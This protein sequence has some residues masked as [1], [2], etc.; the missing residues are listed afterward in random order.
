[1]KKIISTIIV[2]TLFACSDSRQDNERLI[3][4]E[5][6]FKGGIYNGQMTAE[7][8]PQGQG[9][10]IWANG[11]RY[12]GEWKDGLRHGEG[13]F[14]SVDTVYRR[15]F[16]LASFDFTYTGQW[17]NDKYDGKGKE[18]WSTHDGFLKDAT[19]HEYDGEFKAGKRHG[20]GTYTRTSP[21]EYLQYTGSFENREKDEIIT[22]FHGEGKGHLRYAKERGKEVQVSEGYFESGNYVGEKPSG[23]DWLAAL[24]KY[25]FN[26]LLPFITFLILR[27]IMVRYVHSNMMK[28]SAASAETLDEKV[29]TGKTEN[30]L[31]AADIEFYEAN[32]ASAIDPQNAIQERQLFRALYAHRRLYITNLIFYFFYI[33]APGVFLYT[34]RSDDPFG[35]F[36]Q[37]PPHYPLIVLALVSGAF[38]LQA[39]LRYLVHRKCDGYLDLFDIFAFLMLGF[40]IK[41]FFET[42]GYVLILLAVT[43]FIINIFM[44]VKARKDA[45]FARNIKMLI[46]R[47]FGSDKNTAF[48]FSKVMRHWRYLGSYFTVVD[49]AYI[50][51]QYRFWMPDTIAH[52]FYFHFAVFASAILVMFFS[53]LYYA[54]LLGRA[55]LNTLAGVQGGLETVGSLNENMLTL[56]IYAITI[57]IAIAPISYFVKNRF[58]ESRLEI[59]RIISKILSRKKGWSFA[60]K[61]LPMYCHDDTWKLAVD[62][63]VDNADG[64]MMDL[65]GY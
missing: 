6:P 42:S 36:V 26:L 62:E 13:T 43:H 44:R 16:N 46:L 61:G 38:V 15:P 5:T 28:K 53:L 60:Y 25:F 14:A 1:M 19:T 24:S 9:T 12:T 3:V 55:A 37:I 18:S 34:K 20:Q 30:A 31:P 48:T 33:A 29:S 45:A 17:Q 27:V 8:V 63:F 22:E 4:G 52:L 59:K 39:S 7:N 40:L 65:R 56:L 64:V 2:F 51:Q 50:R 10:L 41:G 57:I 21:M 32:S 47:V 58:V 49:P 35:F 11:D 54:F 23:I